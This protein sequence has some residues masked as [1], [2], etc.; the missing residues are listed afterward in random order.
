MGTAVRNRI[1]HRSKFTRA[2]LLRVSHATLESV[3]FLF[4]SNDLEVLVERPGSSFRSLWN[5][6]PSNDF[7]DDILLSM[8]SWS[9]KF[10]YWKQA[11]RTDAKQVRKGKLYPN[12]VGH[13]NIH[14]VRDFV[15]FPLLV[16]TSTTNIAKLACQS[17]LTLE[18]CRAF[19][20]QPQDN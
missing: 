10:S 12:E 20:L 11:A 4:A 3:V 13:V 6:R 16:Q 9:Q 7:G 5:P 8:N 2:T 14:N 17:F 19:S 15:D 18:S 1:P